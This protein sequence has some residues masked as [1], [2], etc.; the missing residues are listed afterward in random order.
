MSD[1]ENQPGLITITQA[2]ALLQ[3]T[4]KWIRELCRKGFIE[5][6][7]RGKVHLVSAVRGYIASLK[8]EERRHS[9]TAEARRVQEARAREIEL[10]I[11]RET[12]ELIPTTSAEEIFAEVLGVYRQRLSGLPAAVTRDLA[13][14]DAIDRELEAAIAD[15]REQFRLRKEELLAGS[16]K[17]RR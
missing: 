12:G 16:K 10:R 9:K 6:P 2:A 11:A 7:A 8:D 4:E 13:I 1:T 3:V 5:K 17:G 15:C 14:R